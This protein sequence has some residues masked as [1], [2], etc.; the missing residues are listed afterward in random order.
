MNTNIKQNNRKYAVKM[1]LEVRSRYSYPGSRAN[2]E[3]DNDT[4]GAGGTGETRLRWTQADS[5]KIQIG[6]TTLS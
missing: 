1:L 4:N 2:S 6:N 3:Q 5:A